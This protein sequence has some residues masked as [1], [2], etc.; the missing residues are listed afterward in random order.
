MAIFDIISIGISSIVMI[1]LSKSRL[2]FKNDCVVV[3]IMN[4]TLTYP[5]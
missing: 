2:H 3:I 4:I 1:V 5:K